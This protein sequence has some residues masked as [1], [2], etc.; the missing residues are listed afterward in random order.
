M[1]I[2]RGYL[3]WGIFFVLLGGIPLLARAGILDGDRFGDLGRWWPVLLIVVGLAIVLAR[4]RAVALAGTVIAGVVVG[5][6]AGGALAFGSGWALDIGDCSAAP[7][8]DVQTRSEQGTF[9][10]PASVDLVLDCG[11]LDVQAGP[12]M[13]SL[14]GWGLTARSAGSPPV[15]DS[16]STSLS[17]ASPK[18]GLRR[19]EWQ[20]LLPPAQL[21]AFGLT[22]N[23]G[24]ATADLSG[25]TLTS[26]DA[27]VNAGDARV[28]GGTGPIGDLDAVVNAGRLRLTLA[29]TTNGSV[30]VNAG[31]LDLCVA[32]GATL[33]LEIGD[34]FGF[35]TN[36]EERGLTRVGDTWQRE[37]TGTTTVF[38]N[39]SGNVG[40]F[41]LDPAGGC[42]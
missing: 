34:G 18:D 13:G 29:G 10:G 26:V 38:L 37:G 11:S 31:S 7:P 15:I 16:S 25:A 32:P 39:V 9:S 30:T 1:R 20:L 23:A 42:W 28:L 35:S 3:F 17:I 41:T 40:T 24:S 22:L 8:G 33:R 2:H 21:G 4:T 19:Q 27:T 6:L 36:L 12:S 14:T 5:A